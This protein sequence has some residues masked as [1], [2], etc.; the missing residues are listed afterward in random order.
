MPPLAETPAGL[1]FGDCL[2][3]AV[4]KVTGQPLLFV[5]GD[6]VQTDLEGATRSV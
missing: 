6:F 3:Y 4:A 1:D 5:G 2:T